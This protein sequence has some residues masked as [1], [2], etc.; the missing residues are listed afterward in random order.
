MKQGAM[1]ME[2]EMADSPH[3]KSQADDD[4]EEYEYRQVKYKDFIT[5]PKYIRSSP[6]P[7]PT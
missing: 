1:A 3:K 4:I 5:K 6:W 2:T 7:P